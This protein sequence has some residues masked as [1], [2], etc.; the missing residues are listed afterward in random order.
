MGRLISV[1]EARNNKIAMHFRTRK[2]GDCL[3][4]S[5]G[6]DFVQIMATDDQLRQAFSDLLGEVDSKTRMGT[7]PFGDTYR[8]KTLSGTFMI[9]AHLAE[10]L[11]A[12]VAAYVV[13]QD[14]GADLLELYKPN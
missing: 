14:I 10:E 1:S 6:T 9:D 11:A 8:F 12:E 4:A 2:I 7:Y 5:D 3:Y 13:E